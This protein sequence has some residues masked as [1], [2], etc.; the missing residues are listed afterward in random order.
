MIWYQSVKEY[1]AQNTITCFIKLSQYT[2]IFYTYGN[3][4]T[5][6]FKSFTRV[7]SSAQL[8]LW[9]FCERKGYGYKITVV[10]HWNVKVT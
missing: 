2:K 9:V 1:V 8:K 7:Y 3:E 10:E 4:Y 6:E 5:L